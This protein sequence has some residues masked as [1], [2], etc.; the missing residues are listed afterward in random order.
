MP[1]SS[2]SAAAAD[3]VLVGSASTPATTTSTSIVDLVTISSLSIAATK[4]IRITFNWRKTATN[5][6]AVGFGLKLNATTVITAVASG[7]GAAE[8]TATQ[9]AEDGYTIIEIG[10]RRANYQTGIVIMGGTRVSGTGASGAVV[11]FRGNTMAA[12]LPTDVITDVIITAINTT[13]NNNAEITDVKV[14]TY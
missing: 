5:A 11:Q 7:N 1:Q 10:P 12:V 4:S 14:I 3:V 2:G 13:S 9:Q 6:T 8:S